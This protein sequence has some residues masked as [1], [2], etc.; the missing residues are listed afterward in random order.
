MNRIIRYSL[1]FGFL[2]L[3]SGCATVV[4]PEGGPKD[5]TPPMPVNYSPQN[6]VRNYKGQKIE[7]RF[8]EFIEL[9]DLNNQL[10]VSPAMPE[11]PDISVKGKKLIIKPP[12]SL[13][14]NTTYTIFLGNAVVNYTEGLPAGNFQYVLATGAELDSLRIRG[15]LRSAFNLK[16]ADGV[17]VMLYKNAND[18]TPYKERPYYLSKTYGNGAFV[19]DNLSE[20]NYLIFAL[21]DLNS[22][23]LYDQPTEEIA[24][25]DS[26]II[27]APVKPKEDTLDLIH[28]VI[29]DM[30]LFTEIA[31]KQV[32]SS[33]KV[34]AEN[35]L[36]LTFSKPA[37]NLTLEPVDFPTIEGWSYKVW[38]SHRDSLD[39]WLI[40]SMPD[41][42][43][44]KISEN[45]QVLDTMRFVLRKPKTEQGR[46]NRRNDTKL[47]D[48]EKDDSAKILITRLKIANGGAEVD[49]FG[50][51]FIR[52]LTPIRSVNTDK[53]QL[54]KLVD[55]IKTPIPLTI[56]TNS[57]ATKAKLTLKAEL[58]ESAK[59][60]I[61]IPD[62]AVYD[63]FGNTN[64][65]ADFSFVTTKKRNYGS[66]RIAVNHTFAEPIL[67]QLLND[68]D[69]LIHQVEL[70][71]SII[72]FPFLKPGNYK[73]KAILDK[74]NNKKWDT[75]DYQKKQL[76]ERV[77]YM[78]E[79]LNI[80]ANWD[81]EQRWIIE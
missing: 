46:R 21:K 5:S 47:P 28:P 73:I 29:L 44:L 79:A 59:Y 3:I 69:A 49:F 62:S 18:S 6:K 9:K 25:L 63:I 61:F 58:E 27:P 41:T 50:N 33:G 77:F 14:K 37:E 2:L 76:P 72:F 7:I 8:D 45:Q 81:V 17:L 56:D 75:G 20:G 4:P 26:L 38:N 74:N 22:N 34:L 13:E 35:H 32:I 48:V 36:L 43:F 65:T 15:T 40:G 39:L 60:S 66:L 31:K 64:D 54:F 51:P 53:I 19:L 24:F 42:L 52:F 10:V 80:R 57:L 78:N 68:K 67:I 30:F 55:T 12:D 71:D 70:T 1:F 11:D 23:Y 16:P